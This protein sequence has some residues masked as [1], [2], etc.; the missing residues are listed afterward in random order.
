MKQICFKADVQYEKFENVQSP[1]ID[2]G[3]Y[4][5]YY[6]YYYSRVADCC[7]RCTGQLEKLQG[8]SKRVDYHL[9]VQM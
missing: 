7:R 1:L 2:S 5:I 9:H 4:Q 8:W 6:Y 3:T